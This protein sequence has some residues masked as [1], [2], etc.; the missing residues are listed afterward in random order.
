MSN[1]KQNQAAPAWAGVP[2]SPLS[3]QELHVLR[4][5]LGLTRSRESYRHYYCAGPGAHSFATCEALVE[6]GLMT[7]SKNRLNEMSEDYIFQVT[8][9]GKMAAANMIYTHVRAAPVRGFVNA[10]AERGAA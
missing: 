8:D 10:L 9:T 3:H 7:R 4:H 1:D 5:S 6:K 2:G